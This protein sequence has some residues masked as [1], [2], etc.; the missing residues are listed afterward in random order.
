MFLI[1][2]AK[3]YFSPSCKSDE[4]LIYY[5]AE[6]HKIHRYPFTSLFDSDIL[7]VPLTKFQKEEYKKILKVKEKFMILGV[8]QFIHRKGWD[9]LLQSS[10]E[11]A[12][13]IGIYIVG[14]EPTDEYKKIKTSLGKENIYFEGFK[15]KEELKKYYMA[16]DLFVLPTRED[17]WGLVVNEALSFGVPVIT[18]KQCIAG[19]ELVSANNGALIEGENPSL[20]AEVINE[21]KD[22]ELS[23]QCLN[24][25]RNYTIEKM[26]LAHLT[27]LDGEK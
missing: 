13:N 2:G 21:I 11:L 7:K 4:Y 22:K 6:K 1:S 8:G 9:I 23:E 25:A 17:I 24:I 26:V 18:T 12:D 27:V 20:L 14:S 19:N 3:G 15:T 10:K 5:G 16:A